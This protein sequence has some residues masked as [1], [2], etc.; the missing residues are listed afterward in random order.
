MKNKYS[1]DIIKNTNKYSIIVYENGIKTNFTIDG[2]IGDEKYKILIKNNGGKELPVMIN[3]NTK[4][5]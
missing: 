3:I 2:I 1:T 4:N 5:K